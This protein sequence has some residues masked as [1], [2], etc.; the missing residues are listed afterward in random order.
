MISEL[1]KQRM[2]NG[3]IV[4]CETREQYEQLL[5]IAEEAINGFD[6]ASCISYDKRRGYRFN[7][8]NSCAYHA[9]WEWYTDGDGAQEYTNCPRLTFDELLEQY[10]YAKFPV[11]EDILE[12][13]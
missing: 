9:F 3:V 5:R 7:R 8:R 2:R 1:L 12:L 13:L 11:L 6:I 4:H 10:S